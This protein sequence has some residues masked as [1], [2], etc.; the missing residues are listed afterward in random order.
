[1]SRSCQKWNIEN[2]AKSRESDGDGVADGWGV[3]DSVSSEENSENQRS[4]GWELEGEAQE[5]HKPR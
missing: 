2:G 4:G 1:M 3:R 5:H